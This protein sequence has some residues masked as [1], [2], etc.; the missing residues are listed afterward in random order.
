MYRMYGTPHTTGNSATLS[1]T[2]GMCVFLMRKLSNTIKYVPYAVKI[3]IR[4][5]IYNFST[6]P[7]TVYTFKRPFILTL[8]AEATYSASPCVVHL[9]PPPLYP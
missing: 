8:A 3:F 6:L 7:Y 2:P 5:N 9:T 4:F 1:K